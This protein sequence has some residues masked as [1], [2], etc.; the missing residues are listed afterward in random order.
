[1]AYGPQRE[2]SRFT[3]LHNFGE[4]IDIPY[5]SWLLQD[6]DQ[7]LNV[8]VD[9]GCSAS[10]Y[11]KHIKPID[12]EAL[13]HYGESFA[14]VVDIKPLKQLLGDRG[15]GTV[16]IDFI[17]ITH[18][19]WDHC[20]NLTLFSDTKVYVQTR[21]WEALPPHPLIATGFAPDSHYEEMERKGR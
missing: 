11:A 4:K 19:D 1:M 13:R 21:E 16:D 7:N 9:V 20:M 8:L 17:I 5:V 14:D 18:L 15:L 12:S 2:K 3:F 6:P 10:Q